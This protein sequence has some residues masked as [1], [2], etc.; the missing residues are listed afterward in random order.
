MNSGSFVTIDLA[1]DIARQEKAD[2]MVASQKLR[3]LAMA[4]GAKDKM[5]VMVLGISDLRKRNNSRFRGT[6]PLDG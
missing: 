5:M 3:D 2:L 4:Y 1:I 6:S